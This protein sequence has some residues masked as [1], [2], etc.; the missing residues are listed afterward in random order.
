M[1][2]TSGLSMH[3]F[4]QALCLTLMLSRLWGAR[5]SALLAFAPPF[6]I[7]C[8]ETRSYFQEHKGRGISARSTGVW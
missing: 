3:T 2:L 1:F 8:A 5:F 6:K 7:E 4:P